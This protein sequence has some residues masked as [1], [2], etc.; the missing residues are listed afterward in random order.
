MA[1]CQGCFFQLTGISPV[2]CCHRCAQ[3]PGSHGPHCQQIPFLAHHHHHH[4]HHQQPPPVQYPP[5]PSA[6]PMPTPTPAPAPAPIMKEAK[7]R[8][9]NY[10]QTGVCSGYCCI[11][12]S[13]TGA[14]GLFCKK[15]QCIQGVWTDGTV[16]VPSTIQQDGV[17]IIVTNPSQPWSPSHGKI[18]SNGK[19]EFNNGGLKGLS[20]GYDSKTHVISFTNGIRWVIQPPLQGNWRAEQSNDVVTINQQGA[21]FTALSPSN[22]WAPS[23]GTHH[24]NNGLT[25]SSGGLAS[26]TGNFDPKQNRITFSNNCSWVKM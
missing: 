22:A 10:V 26:L 24:S 9:C 6:P 25:F 2:H 4:H 19:I 15:T 16:P 21:N 18:H 1:K 14:H 13:L 20:G 17:K 5:V 11:A 3:E 12:C 8:R 23:T 7:C